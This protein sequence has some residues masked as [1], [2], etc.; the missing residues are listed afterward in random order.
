MKYN[1][2]ILTADK[3]INPSLDWYNLQVLLEDELLMNAL[4]EKEISVQRKS[5]SDESVDWSQTSYVIFRSTWDYFDRYNEFSKW[6]DDVSTKTILLNSAKTIHWN[7]DKH[8]LNDLKEKGINVVETYFLEQGKSFKL[9]SHMNALNMK[10]AILKPAISGGARHTYKINIESADDYNSILTE[11]LKEE[12]MM[13]QPFQEDIVKNG[14][15]S[16]IVIGGVYTHAVRKIAKKGD[17]RVQDDHGGVT[18]AHTPTKAEIKFAEKA[19]SACDELPLYA[20]VDIIHDNDGHLAIMELELIEPE[21]FFR[22]YKPATT[23]LAD[24]IIKRI[25]KQFL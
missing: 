23:I 1:V 25:K 2:T 18:I 11:R 24:E 7:L 6:L 20:R 19:I 15:L 5:W 16:L 10:Q 8:Y 22:Y 4:K 21:L 14:E 13:I 3:L 9:I 17:F 12:A